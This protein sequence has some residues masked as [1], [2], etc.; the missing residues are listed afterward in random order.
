M[1][2]KA[3][4]F[5]A[6]TFRFFRELGRNNRKAWMDS[7]RERYRAHV[8][9]PLRALLDALAPLAQQ[10]NPDFDTTGRTVRNFS[11]INLYVRFAAYKPI[12]PSMTYPTVTDNRYPHGD[13]I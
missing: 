2:G 10:L 3:A 11:R 9:E 1:G 12:Y 4:I 6:E 5:S 7:N 8:V 13:D